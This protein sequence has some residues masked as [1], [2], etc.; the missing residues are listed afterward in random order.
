MNPW[1]R[2]VLFLHSSLMS[3]FLPPET[4]DQIVRYFV[5]A[6]PQHSYELSLERV[7]AHWQSLVD[8]MKVSKSW[9]G[10]GVRYLYSYIWIIRE[11]SNKSI[12]RYFLL[13]LRTLRE[14][15]GLSKL[16]RKLTVSN[17]GTE[18]GLK[19]EQLEEFLLLCQNAFLLVLDARTPNDPTKLRAVISQMPSLRTLEM[20][21]F[22]DESV[23]Q[24]EYFFHDDVEIIRFVMTMRNLVNFSINCRML[25]TTKE[26]W[27][28]VQ[29]DTTEAGRPDDRANTVSDSTGI[30]S[31]LYS[32]LRLKTLELLHAGDMTGKSLELL[33]S[34]TLPYL[35]SVS[36]QISPS[37]H[38]YAGVLQCLN[39]WPEALEVLNVCDEMARY[40]ESL[41]VPMDFDI[42]YTKAIDKFPHL[43]FLS[44]RKGFVNMDYFLGKPSLEQ[45]VYEG[46]LSDEEFDTLARKLEE[47]VPGSQGRVYANLPSL[48]L[49]EIQW[50]NRRLSLEDERV[51]RMDAI[52]RSR[53]MHLVIVT[54]IPLLFQ[55][56]N[57]ILRH[58][59]LYETIVCSSSFPS[60][61]CIY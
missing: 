34:V 15:Q 43:Y 13:L 12:R 57:R 2:Y 42:S 33:A 25:P 56:G 4:L 10:A 22:R 27:K 45:I 39:K 16:V 52:S 14:N 7:P 18:G 60:L 50:G 46:R 47:T 48:H 19:Q 49:L 30:N 5:Y 59:R 31:P 38:T 32:T 8:I 28:S 41:S 24:S 20:K 58:Y 3:P 54:R 9:H 61:Q 55:V 17:L 40:S 21:V 53:Q 1:L 23:P 44:T 11:D 35:K 29:E 36:F 51:Q 26:R 37:D 6:I